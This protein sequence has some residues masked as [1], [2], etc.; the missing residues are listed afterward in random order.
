MRRRK[1][2]PETSGKGGEVS[3]V[4]VLGETRSLRG[5]EP[6]VERVRGEGNLRY[7][8]LGDSEAVMG[9]KT[10]S[11]LKG[12]GGGQREKPEGWGC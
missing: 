5:K 3:G 4:G 8:G 12:G 7:P 11:N 2:Q 1:T 10:C 9:W 6:T